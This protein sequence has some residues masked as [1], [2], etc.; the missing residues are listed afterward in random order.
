MNVKIHPHLGVGLKMTVNVPPITRKV[1][2]HFHVQFTFT[3]LERGHLSLEGPKIPEVSKLA[4][5]SV[6][7]S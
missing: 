5:L 2:G 7:V 6:F 4:L 3:V 1:T